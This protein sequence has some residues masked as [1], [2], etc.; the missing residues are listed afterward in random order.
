MWQ[1]ILKIEDM[2]E[3]DFEPSPKKRSEFDRPVKPA[4][5]EETKEY[6]ASIDEKSYDGSATIAALKLLIENWNPDIA[7][8][9]AEVIRLHK[10]NNR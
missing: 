4:T 8:S 2:G 3:W 10:Q 9:A 1:N 7:I 6:L 5:L